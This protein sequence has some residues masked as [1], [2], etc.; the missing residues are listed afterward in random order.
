LE[1]W[2][3]FANHFVGYRDETG[4][5]MHLIIED[6]SFALTAVKMLQKHGQIQ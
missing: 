6:D 1:R 5:Q 4:Q 3:V 2:L